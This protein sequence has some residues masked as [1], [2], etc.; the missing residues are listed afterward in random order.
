MD[1]EV[2]LPLAAAF[3]CAVLLALVAL[4]AYG[5]H[6]GRHL[7]DDLARRLLA[8]RHGTAGSWGESLAPLADPLPL[9]ALLAAACGVAFA[10]GRPSLALGAVIAVGGANLTTQALKFVFAHPRAQQFLGGGADI[11]DVAFP[12]GHATAAASMAVALAIVVPGRLR[13]LAALAGG[14]FALAVGAAVVVI[15]WH[16]P[17][18]VLGGYLVAAGWGFLALAALAA[19]RGRTRD[20]EPDQVPS[21]PAI[22]VK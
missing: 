19:L 5:S 18:D 21:S 3:L 16:L 10:R 8:H 7:D 13:A 2:K 6:F 15:G 11:G 1:E 20:R 14:A 12:S 9:V 4:I 22:S 17:S